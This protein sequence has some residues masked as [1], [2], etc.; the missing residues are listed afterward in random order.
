MSRAPYNRDVDLLV[1]DGVEDFRLNRPC[2]R[3]EAGWIYSTI[4]SL[5]PSRFK[6]LGWRERE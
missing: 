3:T 4:K 6:L 1:T 5:V 2:R